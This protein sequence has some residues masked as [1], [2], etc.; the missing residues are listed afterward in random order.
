MEKAPHPDPNDAEL[1]YQLMRQEL[2]TEYGVFTDAA[3]DEIIAQV[4]VD[5]KLLEE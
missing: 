2:M 1:N 5:R 3:L 4:L